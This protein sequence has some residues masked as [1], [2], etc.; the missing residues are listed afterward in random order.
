M[1][2]FSKFFRDNYSHGQ[3][4]LKRRLKSSIISENLT[5]ISNSNLTLLR[6]FLALRQTIEEIKDQRRR[7]YDFYNSMTSSDTS[8]PLLSQSA[9]ANM[10]FSTMQ[11]I[12]LYNTMRKAR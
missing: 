10:R 6:K 4:H 9:S 5:A 1:V 12:R 7:D 3:L 8:G 2:N 11:Q